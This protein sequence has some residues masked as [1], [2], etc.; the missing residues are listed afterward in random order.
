MSQ[1]YLLLDGALIDNLP[2]RL[3]EL[4]GST[5]FH[6]LYQQTAYSTL[7]TVSPVLVP[8]VPNSP[9]AHTFTE[10]WR[11]TAGI[12]LE[13]EVD[14]AAVLQHLRSLI[15]ARVEGD[16][17]VF[18]RYYDPRITHLWL[19]DL[20]PQ[21]RDRLMG[22]IRLILLPESVHPGGLIR[23]E[24]PEQPIAQYTDKPWLLLT[25]EQVDH[26]SAAKRQGLAQQLI[27][28]CQQHF[29]QRL[30]GLE[31]AAQQQWTL[32]CQ[33]SAERHGYSAADQI[34]RWA[35][36]HA[37]LGDDF[38]NAADHAVYRQ[39]LDDKGASPAQRLDNLNTELH[40]QLL[41]DKDLSA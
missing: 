40:R 17:R 1:A 34:T 13:S 6:A 4:A 39:I 41:I 26:L 22:P 25:P 37:A 31:P 29:P 18:F 8:V 35:N 24:N 19:A 3:F 38:P 36:L 9:L 16:V 2:S 11:A 7:V 21:Q 14:E 30:Q 32:A 27:E 12:W 10:E 23:Q 15:H 28:H 5:A 33:R 20:V